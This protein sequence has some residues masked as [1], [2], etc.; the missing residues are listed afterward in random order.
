MLVNDYRLSTYHLGTIAFF[1]ALCVYLLLLANGQEIS[2]LDIIYI[3]GNINDGTNALLNTV[4]GFITFTFFLGVILVLIGSFKQNLFIKKSGLYLITPHVQTMKYATGLFS[5][6]T[7]MT[8]ILFTFAL[9]FIFKKILFDGV[10]GAKIIQFLFSNLTYN[11]MI[12]YFVII[13]VFILSDLLVEIINW[14][15]SFKNEVANKAKAFFI[16]YYH[17]FLKLYIKIWV[18]LYIKPIILIYKITKL[19]IKRIKSILSNFKLTS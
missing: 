2:F 14:E 8:I 3:F 6:P 15:Y 7:F 16:N 1:Q 18:F 13:A 17:D 10:S 12:L 11:E 9:P 19:L 5:V 4:I